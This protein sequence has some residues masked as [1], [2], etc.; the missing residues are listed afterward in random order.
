ME[1][2]K[3]EAG[4]TNSNGTTEAV[5][6]IY[7]PQEIKVRNELIKICTAARDERERPHNEFDGMTYSQ[8]YDTNKKADMSYIPPKINKD[9][10][11]I[12]TGITREKDNTLLSSLLAY[13]FKADITAYDD[14]EMIFPQLGN[15]ME[16]IVTKSRELEQWE[17]IRP[18]LYRE[19]IAQG[20]VFWEDIWECVYTPE[21]K[22]EGNWKPGQKIADAEFKK[23]L[24]PTKFERAAVKLH[25][26]KNVYVSNFYEMDHK[27]Q[28]T[29]FTYE[30]IDRSVAEAIYGTWDRWE[31]VP[32]TLR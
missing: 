11:R 19:L 31:S 1:K 21:F 32:C 8:N 16:D 4:Q 10:K 2:T 30:V 18:L 25:P 20:D 29:V 3:G 26:G 24:I 15:N 6:V 27:K 9:D 22:N 7:S 5:P 13:N 23:S 14:T 12:V 17:K 28:A